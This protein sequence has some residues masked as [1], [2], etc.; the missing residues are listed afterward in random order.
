MLNIAQASND[1]MLVEPDLRIRPLAGRI[2]AEIVGFK[3]SGD[4]SPAVVA[5]L[6][7]ALARYKVIFF[8]AQ[9]HVD[10][11]LQE[12]FAACLGKILPHPNLPMRGRTKGVIEFDG[13]NN[14]RDDRWHT[15]MSYVAA[16]PVA[17]I[18]RA[19][20]VPKSGGDTCW[21]NT[22]QAYADLPPDLR[23]LADQLWAIHTND[24][25]Y[26]SHL[27]YTAH[28]PN[29]TDEGMREHRAV[30][31][32]NLYRTD[33]PLVRVHPATGE[34]TLLLGCF[35]SRFI[36]W[37]QADSDRLFDILQNRTIRLENTVRWH[38]SVGDIAVWDNYATQHY[39]INDYGF[40]DRVM[41]RVSLEGEVAIGLNGSRSIER[42]VKRS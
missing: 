14:G 18:L 35:L 32:A 31:T 38:W 26:E 34:R 37:P 12:K 36:G 16:Y 7:A 10:D 39:A 6:H 22:V 29:M 2:G 15:D 27:A 17:S 25:D 3:V 30:F 8:S 4:L 40:Q 1:E 5:G 42:V 9:T 19:V 23:S 13:A 20:V 21:A 24:Y 41:R 28:R 11:L 33:H